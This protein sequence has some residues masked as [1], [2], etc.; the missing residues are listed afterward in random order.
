MTEPIKTQFELLACLMQAFRETEYAAHELEERDTA[1][2]A[3]L[4]I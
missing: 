3:P 4:D 2:N 1:E